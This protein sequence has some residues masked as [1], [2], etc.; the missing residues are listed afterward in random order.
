MVRL[1]RVNK[2]VK[3][4]K[5]QPVHKHFVH[6]K[7]PPRIK[8][9]HR[10]FDKKCF[11]SERKN[12]EKH[13]YESHLYSWNQINIFG[14]EHKTNFWLLFS[15]DERPKSS[16]VTKKF[17]PDSIQHFWFRPQKP[18]RDFSSFYLIN[19]RELNCISRNI[20]FVEWSEGRGSDKFA[21]MTSEKD[22][23]IFKNTIVML[24]LFTFTSEYRFLITICKYTL[25]IACNL[26]TTRNRNFSR[27]A[28]WTL[29][30]PTFFFLPS[31]F[32][33]FT[34]QVASRRDTE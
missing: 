34:Y 31:N 24:L 30:A 15:M 25:Q 5:S 28:I 33:T 19:S 4:A 21:R 32:P 16:K 20:L 8:K 9:N 29:K 22:K 13:F 10:E 7:G 1:R 27:N 26:W 12:E 23:I 17:P 18:S 11:L 2:S 14:V 3:S 6:G